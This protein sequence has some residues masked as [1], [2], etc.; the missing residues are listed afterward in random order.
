M[1]ENIKNETSDNGYVFNSQDYTVN[2]IFFNGDHAMQ[3][4][5]GHIVSIIVEESIYGIFPTVQLSVNTSGNFLENLVEDITN[6]LN[7]RLFSKSFNFNSDGKE[8]FYISVS[9]TIR[10]KN[11]RDHYSFQG[12]YHVREEQEFVDGGGTTKIKKYNLLDI[13]EQLLIDSNI[14]WNTAAAKKRNLNLNFNSGQVSNSFRKEKT[15]LA[16]KDLL[17]NFLGL[18]DKNFA[19]DWDIGETDVFYSS[20]P[21]SV[22]YDDLEYLL[23]RHVSKNTGDYCFLTYDRQIK[24]FS[25]RSIEDYFKKGYSKNNIAP[26]I[27]DSFVGEAGVYTESSDPNV[28]GKV[29]PGNHGLSENL[30][31]E[32]EGLENFSLLNIDNEFSSNKMISRAVHVYDNKQ[33]IIEQSNH[34]I[35][36]AKNQIQDRHANNMPGSR[37]FSTASAIL[38]INE[39]KATNKLID[40]VT[41]PSGV[42]EERF[43]MGVNHIINK[44][45]AG[46]PMINF[47]IAGS[48][49]RTVG[50]FI[51]LTL[52]NVDKDSYMSKLLPGE[53]FTT[54][55]THSFL[56]K[57]NQ[58]INNIDC[59]KM[60][61]SEPTY[62]V[63]INWD[64]VGERA[65]VGTLDETT[66]EVR[67]EVVEE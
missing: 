47:E 13:R 19:S 52:R 4:S 43:P 59:V 44:T 67:L 29:M 3:I 61:T 49:H 62:E 14:E 30:L 57:N 1:K 25:L 17:T 12:V 5:N 28:T 40:H 37:G 31:F 32:F 36:E 21:Q 38:P 42:K 7:E 60:H 58:Y 6:E 39:Q 8:Y 2:V 56:F 63:N 9:P 48:G 65:V 16:I 34:T 51:L 24:A 55:I 66:G 26:F 10:E 15:G 41:G 33:F 35:L 54:R 46:A 23:D 27:I 45:F 20:S 64:N 11:L 18:T 50:R 53:W 22:V